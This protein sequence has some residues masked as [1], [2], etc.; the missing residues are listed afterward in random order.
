MKNTSINKKQKQKENNDAIRFH[1]DMSNSWY[2][3]FSYWSVIFFLFY[4]LQLIPFSPY[5]LYLC[6]VIFIASEIL[7]LIFY[8]IYYRIRQPSNPNIIRTKPAWY[9]IIGWLSLVLLLDIIPFF[10]L[11]PKI[12]LESILFTGILILVYLLICLNNNIKMESQ[13]FTKGIKFN[14]ASKKYNLQEYIFG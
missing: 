4:I 8:Q 6:I 11:E 1:K 9:I 3:Y 14:E 7:Y 2:Y 12:N 10:L 13:Y 5:L